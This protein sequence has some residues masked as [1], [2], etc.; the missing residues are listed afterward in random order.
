MNAPSV[1]A[2]IDACVRCGVPL[3]AD[4]FLREQVG[5]RRCRFH[6][7]ATTSQLRAGRFVTVYPCCDRVPALESGLVAHCTRIAGGCTSCDHSPV[8]PAP[9]AWPLPAYLFLAT[10]HYAVAAVGADRSAAPL[11]AAVGAAARGVPAYWE[12]LSSQVVARVDAAERRFNARDNID[13]SAAG[14]GQSWQPRPLESFDTPTA[15]PPPPAAKKVPTDPES[16]ARAAAAAADQAARARL[17]VTLAGGRVA[18]DAVTVRRARTAERMAATCAPP[19]PTIVW[20][21]THDPP[22]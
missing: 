18:T 3:D 15:P 2:P 17:A 11:A 5:R 16:R 9:A 14:R 8:A 20:V 7:S 21:R 19:L 6:P 1:S 12:S 13:A 4:T 10:S 22:A